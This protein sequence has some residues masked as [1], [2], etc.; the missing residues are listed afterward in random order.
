M[1]HQKEGGY[2]TKKQIFTQVLLFFSS[3]YVLDLILSW[4]EL[5]LLRLLNGSL[6]YATNPI[7]ACMHICMHLHAWLLHACMH[8]YV[9]AC[10]L[11]FSMHA[12]TH[13][14]VHACTLGFCVCALL[15]SVC[16][17]ACMHA[18]MHACSL[19]GRGVY[20]RFWCRIFLY[21]CFQAAAAC[22]SPSVE[23]LKLSLFS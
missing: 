23:V 15:A 18:C 21:F 5:K 10:T 12:C 16:V 22:L 13:A 11:S 14:Y 3:F 6:R 20:R 9:H 4:R 19:N 2:A 17:H 8:A 7:C 1:Q